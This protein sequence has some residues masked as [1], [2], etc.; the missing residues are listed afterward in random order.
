MPDIFAQGDC[1]LLS[2]LSFI[3]LGVG[4]FLA[5]LRFS[6]SREVQNKAESALRESESRYRTLFE[7]TTD[8]LLVILPDGQVI[9]CNEAAGRFFELSVQEILNTNINTIIDVDLRGYDAIPYNDRTVEV[10]YKFNEQTK[11]LN[12][13]FTPC[14]WNEKKALFGMGK[15]TTERRQAEEQIRYLAFHDNLTGLPNRHSFRDHLNKC[16]T[17]AKKH[18]KTVG[19]L[20]LDLDRFKIINDTLGHNTGDRLLQ[21]VANRLKRCVRGSDMVARLGGDEFTVLLPELSQL[22]DCIKVS[23]K[24]VNRFQKPLKVGRREFHITPSIGIATFPRDGCDAETLLINAD[25]A[26]YRAKAQGRPKFLMYSPSMNEQ[27]MARMELENALYQALNKG[28]IL[29]HFQPLIQVSTGKIIGMEALARWNQQDRGMISPNDF[30]PM[31]EETGLIIPI[32]EHVLYN[33]CKQNAQWL[34]QGY[35][36]LKVGVNLSSCQFRQC[37]LVPMIGRILKDTGMDAR[38]LELE[39]TESTA[40]QDMEYT[41]SVVNELKQMGASISLDDFGT[42]YAS[43]GYLKMFTALDALKI[44]RS[45]ICDIT[46]SE[47]ASK[48]L[49]A[50]MIV[51]ARNLNL[52]VVAEG[53]ET[54]EQLDFLVKHG[55]D[56]IQGYLCNKPVS[57][58]D[59]EAL[60]IKQTQMNSGYLKRVK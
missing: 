40:M 37:D 34:K 8:P 24:I 47:N 29:V 35:S 52:K 49:V 25:A 43:L 44:D 20:F 11:Y 4:F 54:D 23:Q 33:A 38:F 58:E 6:K 32:G 39:I 28:E 9:E 36:P 31:A 13:T 5:R 16:L 46:D 42:G 10:E 7:N 48:A 19:V 12:L 14:I 1:T 51:L 55:C 57:A 18:G 45:F 60:L 56:V 3:V 22:D 30:I 2:A 17:W 27:A 21:A 53:V 50:T 15:N 59:F 26:M 41:V